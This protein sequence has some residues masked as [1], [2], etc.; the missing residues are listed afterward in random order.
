[1][2][3][4]M[5]PAALLCLVSATGAL[6]LDEYMPLPARM[7]E[8]GIGLDRWAVESYFDDSWERQDVRF[9]KKP[10][11]IPLQG[12]FG[13]AENLEGSIAVEYYV[14]DLT[15]KSGFERP[16]LGLK[17]AEPTLGVGGF[18]AVTLPVGF[19]DIVTADPYATLTFGALYGKTLPYITLLANATYSFNTEDQEN[20]KEDEIQ[21]YVKPE[22]GLPIPLLIK[23]KQYLGVNLGLQYQFFFNQVVQGDSESD[24]AHLATVSPGLFYKFNHI[25]ALDTRA[26]FVM[27]G[28]GLRHAPMGVNAMLRF[29]LDESLYNAM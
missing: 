8:V 15:D 1:M 26:Y 2:L 18:L 19:E 5:K 17:Y 23:N 27:A 10:I 25:I 22:Y 3:N 14:Q 4:K 13:L 9:E 16:V 21:F 6:A 29:S 11:Q 24:P 12:K 28:N 20:S 7:M